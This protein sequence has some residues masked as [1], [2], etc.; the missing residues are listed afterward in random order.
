MKARLRE[1]ERSDKVPSNVQGLKVI[2]SVIKG[3]EHLSDTHQLTFGGFPEPTLLNHP[4]V[5]E[6]DEQAPQVARSQLLG[7]PPVAHGRP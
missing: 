2:Y 5:P 1:L 6:R 4:T 3:S 7:D